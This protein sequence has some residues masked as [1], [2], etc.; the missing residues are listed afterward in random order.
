LFSARLSKQEFTKA[1]KSCCLSTYTYSQSVR[2]RSR[3]NLLTNSIA[4]A[5]TI[6]VLRNEKTKDR[7]QKEKKTA[8]DRVA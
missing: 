6:K 7:E 1:V 2:S 8:G 5:K 4:A 3:F